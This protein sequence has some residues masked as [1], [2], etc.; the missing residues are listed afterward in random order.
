MLC[1]ECTGT[2]TT[3]AGGF[4]AGNLK[5][6]IGELVAKVIGYDDQMKGMYLVLENTDISGVIQGQMDSGFSYADLALNNGFIGHIAGVDIYVIRT[7]TFVDATMGS[8]GA[9]TNSGHRLFG[10]KGVSTYCQ[11]RGVQYNEKGVTLKTGLEYEAHGYIGFKAWIP[12][13]GLTI[14]ITL[15]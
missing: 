2:Y 15:A 12:Q 1:E 8:S 13:R 6:I 9:M 14:D 4:S 3:P 5:E 7:G 11:P 10:I